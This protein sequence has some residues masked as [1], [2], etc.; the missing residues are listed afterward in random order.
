MLCNLQAGTSKRNKKE[1]E[2][3]VSN[4]KSAGRAAREGATI[5]A[6]AL[7]EVLSGSDVRTEQKPAIH[8]G[9]H[10][11]CSLLFLYTSVFKQM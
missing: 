3:H 11:T 5:P 1:E 2:Q 4:Q 6:P 9:Y 7:R 10:A 8:Q